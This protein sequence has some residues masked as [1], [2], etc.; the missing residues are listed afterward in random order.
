LTDDVYTLRQQ[1]GKEL[2]TN[3]IDQSKLVSNET[4][5]W[6]LR[7]STNATEGKTVKGILLII[8]IHEEIKQWF[9]GCSQQSSI[10]LLHQNPSRKW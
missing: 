1:K 9:R 2:R 6:N 7:W 5:T 3:D 10:N 8:P 4:R